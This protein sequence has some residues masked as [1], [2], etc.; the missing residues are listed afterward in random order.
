NGPAGQSD[1]SSLIAKGTGA[2][3]TT[4]NEQ[5]ALDVAFGHYRFFTLGNNG[6]IYSA[7]ATVGPNGTWQHVVG[8]YDASTPTSPQMYIY[9][10]GDLSG[11]GP[12]RPANLGGVRASS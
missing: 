7:E 9:V 1:E 4:A 10:N 6:V 2:E 3:G 11:T 5:F 12:G 8:V